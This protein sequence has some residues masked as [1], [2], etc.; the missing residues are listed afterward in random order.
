MK[1]RPAGLFWPLRYQ[2]LK[3]EQPGAPPESIRIGNRNGTAARDIALMTV[4]AA[5]A[6]ALM[7]LSL[8]PHFSC[9]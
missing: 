3:Y 4:S 8:H 5:T 7:N 9:L 2:K 6:A 1:K